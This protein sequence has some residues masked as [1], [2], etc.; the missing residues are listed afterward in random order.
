[1]SKITAS[2]LSQTA[3][4]YVRQSTMSAIG[5]A[6]PER[7]HPREV[8][9]AVRLAAN[10]PGLLGAANRRLAHSDVPG[11]RPITAGAHPYNRRPDKS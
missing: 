2:H 7:L 6:S 10:P 5:I 11:E 3:Y 4:D 1:M 8:P 9:G